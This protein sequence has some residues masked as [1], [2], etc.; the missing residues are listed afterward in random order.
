MKICIACSAGGHLTEVL[1]L[2]GAYRKYDHFFLTARRRDTEDLAKKD[3]VVF[4]TDPGRNLL[5]LVKNAFQSLSVIRKERPDV[6]LSTGAGLA[7][8]ACYFAKMM[9]KKV[10]FID[11]ICRIERPSLSG[12]LA[13]PIASLFLVQWKGMMAK[14]GKKAQYWGSV[15]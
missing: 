15:I 4:L 12:R 8:P 1:Q 13:Y 3:R 14:Y 5:R 9:G 10:I 6:I 2:A 11:S 7:I